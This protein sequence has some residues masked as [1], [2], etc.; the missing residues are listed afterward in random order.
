MEIVSKNHN[1]ITINLLKKAIVVGFYQKHWSPTNRHR[2]LTTY[3]PIHRPP[4][5]R[6]TDWLLLTYFEREDQILNMFCIL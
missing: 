2:P 1:F 3:P 6:P 4:T 5:H